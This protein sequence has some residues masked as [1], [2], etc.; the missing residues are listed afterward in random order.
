MNT[1]R[2][3]RA[4]RSRLA[5]LAAVLLLNL[6]TAPAQT[7]V[8]DSS[9]KIVAEDTVFRPGNEA[10][11]IGWNVAWQK[12]QINFWNTSTQSADSNVTTYLATHFP[13]GLYRYPGGTVASFF[14]WQQTIGPVGNRSAQYT[15]NQGYIHP[16]FGLDE[17]LQLVES[18]GGKPMLSVPLRFERHP[19]NRMLDAEVPAWA[20]SAADM[21]EY[22]NAPNDGTNPGGGTDWA[23]VRAANGHAAPYNVLIWEL[24]NEVDHGSNPLSASAYAARCDQF[25][26]AMRAVD[27][28]IIVLAH[29]RTTLEQATNW[30]TWHETVIDELAGDLD[31]IVAH[32]YYDGIKVPTKLDALST[33]W[34]DAQSLSPAYPP[35]VAVTEHATWTTIDNNNFNARNSSIIGAIGTADF[36]MGS[37]QRE[38]IDLATMH[39]LAGSGWWLAFSKPSS[40]WQAR[41]VT[42]S[43]AMMHAI[44]RASDVLTT[45]VHTPNNG[46]YNGGYDVRGVVTR[47]AS[48]GEYAIGWINRH[49]S[50]YT[51][52]IQIEGL[53]SGSLDG[54]LNYITD[55]TQNLGANANLTV[56]SS[57]PSVSVSSSG[58]YGTFSLS[59]PAKSVGTLVLAT[60]ANPAPAVA[61]T[62]PTVSSVY[63]IG[64]TVPLAATASDADGIA[65]V[66]FYRGGS[67]LIDDDTSS[68]YTASW[69]PTTAGNYTLTAVAHDAGSPS[70]SS[71]SVAV[72][73]TV[74]ADTTPSITSSTL[75]D[76][77]VGVAYTQSL[78]ATGGNGAT[79]WSLDSGSLP[80]GLGLSS[81]GVISGTPS[82]VATATFTVR[83][84]DS[85]S[86][87]GSGDEDT[88]ALALTVYAT[89]AGTTLRIEAGNASNYTDSASNVWAADTG[90]TG[91]NTVDR[92]SIAIANTIDD[93]IYQ[94]E[95]YGMSAFSATVDNGAYTL[96]LHFAE[97]YSAIGTVGERVFSISVEGTAPAALQ[98]IDVYS[99]VGQNA[100]LVKSV[101]V[102]ITDG[103]LDLVFT[104]SALSPIING[105][106][107]VPAA[108]SA[109]SITT[110]TLPDGSIGTAYNQALSATGGDG[111]LTW[112]VDSGSLPAGLTLSS[113]GLISGTPTAGGTASFTARVAD[114][115]G[116]TGPTDED[117]QTLDL[118]ITSTVLRI[119]AG[120]GSPFTDSNGNLWAVDSGFT[121]GSTVDRGS[122]AIAD[123]ADDRIYQTERYGLTA[124][125]ATVASGNYT[126]NLH[127]AET[128][129]VIDTV[130]ERVFSVSVEGV[131]PA[132]LTDLDVLAEVGLNA[133]LIKTV[134]ITITDGTLNLGFIAGVQSTMINGIEL[135]PAP[136]SVPA[137]A[138]AT[139]SDGT[140]GVAYSQTLTALDGNGDLSWS[141]ASGS[142][143]AGL[144]L[145]AAGV[146]SG[147]PT[148]NGTANFTV[149]VADGDIVTGSGDEDTQVLSIMIASGQTTVTFES[150]AAHDGRVVES[151]ETSNVGG[152]VVAD[153]SYGSALRMGD[154]S[155][156]RQVKGI[157]S[158]DTS[159]LPDGATI[160]SATLKLRRGAQSY[161]LAN[162]GALQADIRTGAFS[163]NTALEAADFQAAATATAVA[164]M[165]LPA[166]DGDLS[167]GTLNS[168]GRAAINKTGVTQLR[169]YFTTDD[170]GNSLANYLA[171]WAGEAASSSNRPVLEITYQ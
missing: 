106:E 110:T 5:S 140:V 10:V 165:S 73:V 75:P 74:E 76:A 46:G 124:Y 98:N 44:L 56:Q 16:H 37:A 146:I 64:E 141:L 58:G 125:A 17:F 85:D 96:N 6:P 77:T 163:G 49:S 8:S 89:G 116:N 72:P 134:P 158:F 69:S 122:I 139:L 48:N 63:V 26:T 66:E 24:D 117:T 9:V 4:H 51:A 22:C 23:A 35:T 1:P 131:T 11:A 153:D 2:P 132:S 157:V 102:T 90:F 50:A 119:E 156:R 27:P 84:A 93:K 15:N 170:D 109:P 33:I 81:A 136:N 115:D 166:V 104:S 159:A 161:T 162:L 94:T 32:P 113:A 92:G 28:S 133:A 86:L 168:A 135:L 151:S 57:T 130:G 62:S 18:L 13:G 169:V 68:P 14:D 83:A 126:L 54:T 128:Y 142:L 103:A 95:R 70:A 143:P 60:T 148:T 41:P 7:F 53:P 137:I 31:M 67:T 111:S 25:I 91:G 30:E 79:T 78:A 40:T 108:N 39:V 149:R 101:P 152:S 121:G 127:F 112:S 105:I 36:L 59:L 138:T 47:N 29:A 88:Q 154:Q 82:A 21:V 100:A 144:S 147:T 3:L 155:D 118:T 20:Q 160:V 55:P 65:L 42:Q 97:T 114:A 12:F 150:T 34:S 171:C 71:T 45:T 164:T 107:L 87:T 80:T 19:S 99:A 167:T 61:L 129:S 43:H 52:T 123:T 120:N 145:S 38:G